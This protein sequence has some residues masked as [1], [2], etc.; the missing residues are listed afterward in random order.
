[1]ACEQWLVEIKSWQQGIAAIVAF[2]GLIVAALY[3]ARLNRKRD[4]RLRQEEVRSVAAALYGEMCVLRSRAAGI[5]RQTAAVYIAQGTNGR[6]TV[7]IDEHF[8]R[9]NTLPEQVLY[10]ALAS[11]FG[12][13]P[14]SLIIQI[15]NFYEN[16]NLVETW[17]PQMVDDPKS[18]Y[19]YNVL[20]VLNPALDA[21]LRVMPALEQIENIIDVPKTERATALDLGR[22]EGVADG[23][24]EQ[25]RAYAD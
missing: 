23:E 24:E 3:N 20:H 12:L 5:A 21:V 10:K 8:V 7:K 18:S 22:A 15:T 25:L 2:C 16:I 13:L 6:S 14:P 11:K 4:E 9:A 19:S 1:M 17:L